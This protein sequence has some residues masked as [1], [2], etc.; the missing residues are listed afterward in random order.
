[1]RLFIFLTV[2]IVGVYQFDSIGKFVKTELF[3]S[4]TTLSDETEVAI[5]FADSL[6][7]AIT[8]FEESRESVDKSIEKSTTETLSNIDVIEGSSLRESV[9][10]WAKEWDGVKDRFDDLLNSFDEVKSSSEN[11]FGKLNSIAKKIINPEL[12]AS[13]E[14]KNSELQESWSRVLEESSRNIDSLKELI[15]EGDDFHRVL[16]GTSIREK[17]G[18]S[19]GELQEISK[20]AE[21]LLKELQKLTL[22]GKKLRAGL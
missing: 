15:N 9:K 20:K 17:L 19:I 8:E 13:E 18:D 4:E 1:M 6:Q 7:E 16:L 12:K 14:A 11:Y 22:E 10:K 3:S 2:A 5:E 21:I